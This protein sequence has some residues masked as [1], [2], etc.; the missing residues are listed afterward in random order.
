MKALVL[1]VLTASDMGLLLHTLILLVFRV[2]VCFICNLFGVCVWRE[3]VNT[4]ILKL[5]SI[6]PRKQNYL[7]L[8]LCMTKAIKKSGSL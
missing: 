7:L 6:L 1:T 5:S 8:M 4:C 3:Y 2:L